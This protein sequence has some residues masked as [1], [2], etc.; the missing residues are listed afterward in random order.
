VLL[1]GA[2]VEPDAVIEDSI[3]GP[4]ATVG[5]GATLSGLTVIGHDIQIDPGLALV[6]ARVPAAAD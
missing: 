2:V 5:T 1:P 4:G 6:G 3:I